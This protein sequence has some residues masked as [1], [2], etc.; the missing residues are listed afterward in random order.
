MRSS[1]LSSCLSGGVAALALAAGIA[2]AHA[3]SQPETPPAA[4]PQDAA[5]PAEDNQ[6]TVPDIVV[7]AQKR[8]ERLQDVPLAV[9]SLGANALASSQINGT[10]GV[11]NLVPSLTFT[12]NTSALNNN[13]RIRGV[14]TVLFS[15]GIESSV[16]FVVDGVVMARQGQGFTDLIDV[17]RVEVL[18]GP[19]GML[20]GKNATAGVIN[21]VTKRPAD[22]FEGS[23]EGSVAEKGEY[24]LRGTVSA[25]LSNSVRARLTGFY[26]NDRGWVYD[27]GRKADVYGNKA[28]GLRGKVEVDAGPNL[29]LLL[30]A[31][32]RKSDTDCCQPLA[33]RTTNALLNQLRAPVV[34]SITNRAVN[35]SI[36][37]FSNTREGGVSLEANYH[38]GD[39][40]ITSI[41]AWRKWD[42][43]NNVDV[44]GFNV[45]APVRVPIGFGYF[46]VNGGTVNIR[47]FSQELRLASPSNQPLEYTLGVMYYRLDLD[48]AFVTRRGG[49]PGDT[50]IAY[51]QICPS[52]TFNSASHNAS[53][54]TENYA[55]FGQLQYNITRQFSAI[56]GFRLQRERT[57]YDGVRTGAPAFAGDAA[58]FAASSGSGSVAD[59]SLTGKLGLQYKFS[60]QA[61]VYATWSTGYKGYGYDVEI[62]ANFANQVPVK[63]ETVRSWEV[64]FKGQALNNRSTFNLALFTA[65]YRN[66][67]IQTT[68]LLS[69]GTAVSIPTNAGSS[70]TKGVELELGLRPTDHLT[71]NAGL[72][73]MKAR[74]DAN[75]VPCP[76]PLQ[77]AAITLAAGQAQPNNTCFILAG[78]RVQNVRG[79]ILPNSPEWK[80]NLSA[81]YEDN[82]TSGLVGFLQVNGNLQSDILF[83]LSQDPELNQDGYVT[84]D[85]SAGIKTADD[86]YQLTFFVRNIGNAH[87]A[88]GKI[89]E[90]MLT[91]AANPNNILF[92]TSKDAS[93]YIGGSFRMNF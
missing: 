46:S 85:V 71:F 63:P 59:T 61:Q 35:S 23:I 64:G 6:S 33:Y 90:N 14:G 50:T 82:V 4:A 65:N 67:Q 32:Y 52:P 38:A 41:T 49:C 77:P 91:N 3:Q 8:T 89:R 9:T 62:S 29:D 36:D 56:G 93:R 19:Q 72:T 34:A 74:F 31:D 42:F 37:T 57:S 10:S 86:K 76:L 81:R 45:A 1:P 54:A 24:H 88:T 58:L 7:T 78:A 80:G 39:H 44:D 21:I 13:V 60:R 47:Q 69:D 70:T 22:H 87:Y 68:T 25:P 11:A 75:G 40:T 66:L 92:F 48:R 5:A 26:T 53:T 73:Y 55:A 30:T 12:Q 83:D 43:S 18:R 28:F 84:A 20:F 27:Y 79:G 15:A 16:S 17:D 2:P 51:G